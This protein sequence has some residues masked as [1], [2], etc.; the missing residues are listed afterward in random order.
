M[1]HGIYNGLGDYLLRNLIRCRNFNGLRPRTYRQRNLAQYEVYRLIHQI[2]Y[3]SLVDLIGRDGFCDLRTV[4]MGALDF[5]RDQKPLRRF[6]EQQHGGIGQP[7]LVQQIQVPE[8][9]LWRSIFIQR[10]LSDRASRANQAGHP[11][12]IKIVQRGLFARRR[13]KWPK[14]QQFLAFKVFHQCRIETDYKFFLR[15]EPFS[16]Q[17]GLGLANQRP[18]LRMPNGGIHILQED[19][20]MLPERCSMV[21]FPLRRGH[22]CLVLC[23]VVLSEQPHIDVAASH[24]IQINLVGSPVR[25]RNFLEQEGVETTPH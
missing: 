24:F 23:P 4:V 25:S 11:F 20:A 13:V 16:D 19:Q 5:G 17:A 10:K 15:M 7:P 12:G 2:E 8:Q 21:E 18:H 3:R 14:A 22:S 1:D 6:A 9:V